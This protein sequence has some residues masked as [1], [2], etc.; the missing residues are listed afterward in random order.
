M[1]GDASGEGFGSTWTK[2][3]SVHYRYG[4]W[5]LESEG[6]SSNFRELKN[7]VETLETM[8]S[9][10]ELIGK[11][12]FIFT[13]NMVSESIIAKGS[14]SSPL[15]F[16]LVL[17]VFKLEMQWRCS[18]TFVHV[19]GCFHGASHTIVSMTTTISPNV[20]APW[21]NFFP[22][23]VSLIT[24]AAC[25]LAKNQNLSGI[26]ECTKYDPAL[27]LIMPTNLSASP[28]ACGS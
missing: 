6:T 3:K 9:G 27:P 23:A 24:A 4:V 1:F 8:G 18:I 22:S 14:S 20:G 12:M 16:Q 10:G 21:A 11:E 17:K 19:A 15:L 25:I 26:L 7:L 5:G 28:F 13:D 2:G